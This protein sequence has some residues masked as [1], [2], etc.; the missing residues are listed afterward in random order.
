[1]SVI[2]RV[3]NIRKTPKQRPLLASNGAR[4]MFYTN[5]IQCQRAIVQIHYTKIYKDD[6]MGLEEA[7][8]FNTQYTI[9]IDMIQNL[10]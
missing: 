2:S 6:G 3:V 8:K 10:L 5:F 7:R 9:Y 1:M 4:F